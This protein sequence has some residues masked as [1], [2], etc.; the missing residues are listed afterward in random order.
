MAVTSSD[1]PAGEQRRGHG[2]ENIRMRAAQLGC[3]LT[4]DSSP[5]G[6]T[7]VRVEVPVKQV[8]A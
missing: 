8:M 6:G 2:L 3:D 1:Q 7:S 5:G 4:I